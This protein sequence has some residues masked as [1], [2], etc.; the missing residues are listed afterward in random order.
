M[1]E[2][3][4]D[5]EEVGG[6]IPPLPIRQGE[7][8][9]D[10]VKLRGLLLFLPANGPILGP[11]LIKIQGEKLKMK[12]PGAIIKELIENYPLVLATT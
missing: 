1:V 11:Q 7:L 6:S 5:K 3:F 9:R 12:L 4:S 2:R 8:E 10:K